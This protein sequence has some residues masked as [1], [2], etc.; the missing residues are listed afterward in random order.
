MDFGERKPQTS[1]QLALDFSARGEARKRWS[2]GQL[3][4]PAA[5]AGEAKATPPA[6]ALAEGL[7]EAMGRGWK[8]ERALRKVEANRGAPGVDGMTTQELRPYLVVHWK[9]L[10]Q[11]LREGRY[12]P[13]PVRR[14]EIPKPDGGV[15]E[16]GIPT[17][18]DR[19][20]Q[21][22]SGGA[23]RGV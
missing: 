20:V 21:S 2:K 5:T 18:V 19:F 10:R 3:L 1:E 17:V 16:L 13:Q 6:P 23:P 14:V 11:E 4:S 8:V 9:R 7:T 22:A 15:R 12:H